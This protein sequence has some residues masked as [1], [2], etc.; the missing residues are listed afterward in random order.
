MLIFK[1]A[2]QTTMMLNALV[3]QNS[4]VVPE[5]IKKNQKMV[6]TDRKLKLRQM[7]DTLK[8]LEG[9]VFTILHEHLDTETHTRDTTDTFISNQ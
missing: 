6:L 5:N 9:S 3:A 8:I 2:V 1:V 4:A 7:R